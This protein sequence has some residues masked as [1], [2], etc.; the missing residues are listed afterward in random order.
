MPFSFNFTSFFKPKHAPA[1]H[2]KLP[3]VPLPPTMDNVRVQTIGRLTNDA[4]TSPDY[5][6]APRFCNSYRVLEAYDRAKFEAKMTELTALGWTPVDHTFHIYHSGQLTK[7][8]M[9][10]KGGPLNPLAV[11]NDTAEERPQ[12]PTTGIPPYNPAL[13]GQR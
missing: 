11:I 7:Y 13:A 10:F 3:D 4:T 6:T 8:T 5:V 9:L 1:P 12:P 2:Q